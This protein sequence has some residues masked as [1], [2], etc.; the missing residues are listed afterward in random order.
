MY[1][2]MKCKKKTVQLC[3]QNSATNI[4]RSIKHL[5]QTLNLKKK[6]KKENRVYLS[7]VLKWYILLSSVLPC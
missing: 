4:N 5:A 1:L 7:D 6:K 2:M 3:L